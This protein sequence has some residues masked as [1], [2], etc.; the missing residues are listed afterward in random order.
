MS[1]PDEEDTSL[2]E[3]N[4]SAPLLPLLPPESVLPPESEPLEKGELK[5]SNA[6]V[7]LLLPPNASEKPLNTPSLPPQLQP[8]VSSAATIPNLTV[9]PPNN[10]V[11]PSFL[12]L[13]ILQG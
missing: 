1:D 13:D 9:W 10:E 6:S 8:A 4:A 2:T 11:S 7:L 12:R 3:L 5:A